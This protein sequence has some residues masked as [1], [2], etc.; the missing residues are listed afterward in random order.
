VEK[1]GG[2]RMARSWKEKGDGVR[3]A[4]SWKEKGCRFVALIP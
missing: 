3:M 1:G 2:V 4:R